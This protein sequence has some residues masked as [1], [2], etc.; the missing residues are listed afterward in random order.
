MQEGLWARLALVDEWVLVVFT[1]ISVMGEPRGMSVGRS[2]T[3]L[4]WSVSSVG[5]YVSVQS[6]F[7]RKNLRTIGANVVWD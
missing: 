3:A 7:V 4:V 5:C 2:A 6:R 1:N